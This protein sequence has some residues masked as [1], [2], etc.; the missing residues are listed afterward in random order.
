MPFFPRIKLGSQ[1]LIALTL[2]AVIVASVSGIGLRFIVQSYLTQQVA[3]RAQDKLQVLLSSSLDDI[4]SEDG[5]RLE[6]TVQ[7]LVQKDKQLSAIRVV[8]EV[9]KSLFAWRRTSVP[10]EESLHR[11]STHVVFE[12]ERFGTIFIEWDTID[13]IREIRRHAYLIAAFVGG[14]CLLLGVFVFIIMRT[15]VVRPINRMAQRALAYRRGQFDKT[16]PVASFAST[17]LHRLEAAVDSLGEFL[18]TRDFREAELRTAVEMAETANK[19]KSNFLAN[20]SHELRTPLNAI[21]G[22][23]QFMESELL[24]KLGHPKYA[25]YARDIRV[26]GEHLLDIITEILE[27]SKIEAGRLELELVDL[28]LAATIRQSF[29]FIAAE[30]AESNINAVLDIPEDLPRVRVDELRIKQVLI[31]ILSNASKFT[32]ENG[33]ITVALDWHRDEGM[34][35]RVRDTGKGIAADDIRRVLMP[36]EQVETVMSRDCQGTGLGLPLAKALV[37]LHG[38]RLKLT[39]ELGVGTEVAIWLPPELLVVHADRKEPDLSAILNAANA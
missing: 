3:E 14:T 39:S 10:P 30:L 19:A 22:F 32:S 17:E 12:G 36:F 8:N 1:L 28:D 34:T 5:P 9:G 33:T 37:E 23:S 29:N 27:M 6:T 20:M 7:Q 16:T 15:L 13:D 38:G 31:N 35:L 26:S 21:L 4:I 25:E 11:F 18:K 24:G 2:L